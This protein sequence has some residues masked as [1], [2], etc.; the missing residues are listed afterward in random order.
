[1]LNNEGDVTVDYSRHRYG[2]NGNCKNS[3]NIKFVYC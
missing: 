3:F 1:V 2:W